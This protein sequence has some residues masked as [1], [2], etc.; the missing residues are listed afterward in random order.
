MQRPRRRSPRS[1]A[2]ESR[3]RSSAARGRAADD[4]DARRRREA[5]SGLRRSRGL[6][7]MRSNSSRVDCP[8]RSSSVMRRSSPAAM[9]TRSSRKSPSALLR[10]QAAPGEPLVSLRHPLISNSARGRPRP[11]AACAGVPASESAAAPDRDLCEPDVVEPDGDAVR[12]DQLL[13]HA[14][15]PAETARVAPARRC[16]RRSRSVVRA[17]PSPVWRNSAR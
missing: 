1:R 5:E 13:R 12:D 8:S 11:T 17:H 10:R 4:V 7:S 15:V 2:A 3:I 9:P 14:V 16:P 6:R